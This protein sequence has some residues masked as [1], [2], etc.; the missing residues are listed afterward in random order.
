MSKFK[1]DTLKDL[2]IKSKVDKIIYSPGDIINEWKEKRGYV[3]VYRI[4]KKS[5]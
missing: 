3:D 2:N 1:L 5:G 4:K